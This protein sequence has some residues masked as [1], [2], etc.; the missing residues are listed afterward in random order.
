MAEPESFPLN[1]LDIKEQQ[2]EKLKSL[3]PEV[4]TE[5]T[6]IDWDRLKNT[7]GNYIDPGKERFGLNWPGKSECFR[8]IQQP[9]M[10]TLTP[11]PEESLKANGSPYAKGEGF[12]SGPFLS[13]KLDG[14]SGNLFI[15][16][17][18]LEVLKL[19]Q[20]SYQ[21]KV[22][23][24]YIDPPYNTGNEFIY[25]DN[26]SETLDTYLEYTG[27]TDVE[28]RKFSTNVDTDGRFHSKWLNMMYPRLF[29]AKNL[30]REDGVIFISIDDNEV[31][32]LRGLCN[33]IF[34]EEN[35]VGQLTVIN[36]LKGRND[37]KNIATCHEYL[38][39]FQ[40]SS[41]FS[42]GLPL[43]PDQLK[44]FKHIDQ[45]GEKYALRD[46]RKRGRPD[47]REDRPNMF[48]PIFYNTETL[49]CSLNR[50]SVS[51]IEILPKRGDLS[52]GRWR[53]GKITVEKYLSILH[54]KY[55]K[56]KK[57]W[58]VE[59]RVYLNSGIFE[60]EDEEEEDLEGP[61]E[62]SLNEN[63]IEEEE[64]EGNEDLVRT[65]KSKSFWIGGEI[66]SD[67]GRRTFK[68]LFKGKLEFSYPKAVDFFKKCL[69]MGL[70]PS[71]I[72]LDFFSGSSG[73][74]QAV[75]ELNY[76]DGLGRNFICV[77]LPEII[78]IE[79]AKSK[80]DKQ[81]AKKNM[82]YFEFLKLPSTISEI[83][84]LRIRSSSQLILAAIES[85]TKQIASIRD[86]IKRK[87]DEM[88]VLSSTIPKGLFEEINSVE[89]SE[90]KSKLDLLIVEEKRLL[91][92][93]FIGKKGD[94]GLHVFK[95]QSS[96]FKVW[97]AGVAKDTGAIQ[98]Q[99]FNQVEHISP[100]ASQEDILFEL[101]LKAGFR[102]DTRIESLSLASKQVFSIA[103]GELLI[104]L[105]KELTHEV[106]TTMAERQPSRVICLDLGFQNNDQLKTNAVQIMKSKK[107]LNFQTV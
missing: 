51:D 17:D 9:S 25:P 57:R 22:K 60:F 107:V 70:G 90:I 34:G 4:F 6:R 56:K 59:H 14:A 24:I 20:K 103:D 8:T 74:A 58:D 45:N 40:K 69:S 49:K 36:N 98:T 11:C 38:L 18:N 61:Y 39:V 87:I 55:S 97:D 92:I 77:Q 7:L 43:T 82:E 31:H 21:N 78:D 30:L 53:W 13:G 89:L 33:E 48:F 16:G 93:Q 23:M 75:F 101:L 52:D 81:A 100:K 27:Q 73:I 2:L 105:E 29:L 28:G 66:S 42:R 37:K 84:K 106:I 12:S 76:F 41:F 67:V 44:Q 102:L 71:E 47:R 62:E 94:L 91:K 19:L 26:Y 63:E 10:A 104:C 96:H 72:V 80:E 68:D 35:F 85:T 83:G 88:V 65:S 86:E 95:L 1:S 3:F 50:S 79:K 32:N 5:G 54:P 15:E 99:I 64:E 46:L